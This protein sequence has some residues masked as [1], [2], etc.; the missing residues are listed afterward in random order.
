MQI[1]IS[2]RML[3]NKQREITAAIERLIFSQP[4]VRKIE[5]YPEQYKALERLL[6]G[7]KAVM[8]YKGRAIY[9]GK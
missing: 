7:Q 8:T 5:L 9:R 6:D 4:S 2:E 3:N 1:E